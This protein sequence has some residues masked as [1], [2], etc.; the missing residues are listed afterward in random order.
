MIHIPGYSVATLCFRPQLPPKLEI[1]TDTLA[2]Q[3][4]FEPSVPPRVPRIEVAL[5]RREP[6]IRRNYGAGDHPRLIRRQE[7]CDSSYILRLTD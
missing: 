4:G 7:Q 3:S 6:T 1:A 2:E 5:V